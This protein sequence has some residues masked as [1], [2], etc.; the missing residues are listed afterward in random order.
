[1][2]IRGVLK[3]LGCQNLHLPSPRVNNLLGN[4]T[5]HSAVAV[6][7]VPGDTPV[8]QGWQNLTERYEYDEAGRKTRVINGANE[9]TSY[10]YDLQGNVVRTTQPMTQNTWATFDSQG[11]KLSE[12][13]ANGR[14]ATWSYDTLGRLYQHVDI[15]GATYQ[16]TYDNARQLISQTNSRGL[17]QLSSYDAAGQ[18]VQQRNYIDWIDGHGIWNNTSYSYDL[19]GNHVREKTTQT[20]RMA[21]GSYVDAVYQD[22]QMMYDELGRLVKVSDSRA[23]ADFEYD[24]VGNRI[25]IGTRVTGYDAS[26]AQPEQFEERSRFFKYD[27]MNRQIVVDA[28]DANGTLGEVGHQLTYDKN[29][30]RTSD[31]SWGNRVT[32]KEAG[33]YDVYREDNQGNVTMEQITISAAR[34]LRTPGMSTELYGYDALNR[35]LTVTKDAVLVD[36][37]LYDGAGRTVQSGAAGGLPA[38]YGEALQE[39]RPAGAVGYETRINQ[40][41]ANGR[42]TL[43]RVLTGSYAAKYHLTGQQYDAAGN[44]V[45]YVMTNDVNGLVTNYSYTDPA[46]FEGYKEST[47]TGAPVGQE[48]GSTIS[49]YDV[50][51]NLTSVY[52]TTQEANNRTFVNDAAGRVLM[53]EQAGHRVRELIVN[54]EVLGRY[55]VGINE[56]DP[57]QT[58]GTPNFA[59]LSDLSFGFRAISDRHPAASPGA[60]TV[61]NGD[62]LQSIAHSAYGDSSLWYLVA[63]ANGLQG[64]QDLRIGQTLAV[65]VNTATANNTGSVFS[66]YDP[67]RVVGDT[68]PNLPMP[69]AQDDGGGC[70]GLGQIIMLVVAVVVAIYAPQVL[71]EVFSAL[72][73]GTPGFAQAALASAM[74]SVASQVVGNAIGA[75]DGFS[76]KSVAL[77]ALSGGIGEG[78]GGKGVLPDV[79]SKIGNAILQKAVGSALSQGVAVMTGLQEH[80][81]WRGVVVAGISAGVG[82]AIGDAIGQTEFGKTGLGKF[83]GNFVGQAAGG[84]IA[85]VVT[86]GQVSSRRILGD[87]FG[88]A[89][90]SSLASASSGGGNP[91][92]A[93]DYRNGSDVQSDNYAL[94]A[95][96]QAWNGGSLP[97]LYNRHFGVG[98]QNVDFRRNNGEY[99][100]EQPASMTGT[101]TPVNAPAIPELLLPQGVNPR[102]VVSVQDQSGSVWYG[103]QGADGEVVSRRAD[104]FFGAAQGVVGSGAAGLDRGDFTPSQYMDAVRFLRNSGASLDPQPVFRVEVT[105][106]GDAPSVVVPAEPTVSFNQADLRRFEI[107]HMNAGLAPAVSGVHQFNHGWIGGVGVGIGVPNFHQATPIPA[108]PVLPSSNGSWTNPARPGNSGWVSTNPNVVAITGGK[109]VQFRRGMV[110]F[111]PWSQGR[112]NIPNMTGADSDLRLGRDALRQKYDLPTDEAARRWLRERGLT[113]H[114][115]ANGLSLDLI[116]SDLHNT[117]RGGIPHSGGASILR[118]WN[119]QG[120]P[121]QFYNA[122]RIATGARY[123]GGAAMAYGAYADG[124]SLYE[125]YQVS[126]QS[127]SYANTYAEGARVAGGWAGAWAVGGAFA[128]FGAGFGTAFGPVGTV[129]GGVVG[130]AVG[131]ML[132]YAGG[133]YAAPRVMYDLKAF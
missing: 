93:Y 130:G 11:R 8:P 72:G 59:K 111:D 98:A 1:M 83:T 73:A 115:N 45:S 22:N 7:T 63:Q 29:G 82:V 117:A 48:S 67:S 96:P 109:P 125:Q 107:E 28:I 43:Q 110:N 44:L 112:F 119:V 84:L 74:G 102:T 92:S 95:S 91:A 51:G 26:L 132:G 9:A 127:G 30:N 38:G 14:T 49:R 104:L 16:Y 75:Q 18:L 129:V 86:G 76:W 32:Y 17:T 37:R 106:V 24:K 126:K 6:N 133:S 58:D 120:T 81:S 101:I 61:A 100:V 60:Y 42:L 116:P 47:L 94:S 27:E 56:L 85:N 131:G 114:H 21:D 15:G 40:Y 71:S 19:A 118:G 89:L 25:R 23:Y 2:F 62:T 122:N 70:G 34:Y 31:Y 113:L 52:D 90:G 105:G 50:N 33:T 99:V 3:K 36:S 121:Q 78:L 97:D 65:P 68:S 41:D 53:V 39:G 4:Y 64:N 46:L 10:A 35:L 55:G 128:Q 20:T 88:N 13:D 80:F 12:T 87:A 124:R 5:T 108:N 57:R 54:G 79:G 77:A 103:M 69:Q 66:P 123:L